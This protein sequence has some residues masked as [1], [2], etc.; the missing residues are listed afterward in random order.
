MLAA[1][2]PWGATGTLCVDENRASSARRNAASSAAP[3]STA[4]RSV[5]GARPAKAP[6]KMSHTSSGCSATTAAMCAGSGPGGP[7]PPRLD[8]TDRRRS[9]AAL[10]VSAL[11]GSQARLSGESKENILHAN[12][13]GAS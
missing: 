4:V 3:T 6:P 5:A 8:A 9:T 11:C 12:P 7:R 13:S 1:V 2:S 10:R